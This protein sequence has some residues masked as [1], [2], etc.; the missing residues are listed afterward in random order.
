MFEKVSAS[1]YRLSGRVTIRDSAFMLKALF[2]MMVFK[3]DE[4]V[5]KPV[6]L[7]LEKVEAADSVLLAVILE[8]ARRV[9]SAGGTFKVVGLPASL[10]SL[11]LVYGIEALVASYGMGQ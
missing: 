8:A 6:L 5:G 9:E 10:D 1:H 7:D 2:V 3:K 4:L 11:V